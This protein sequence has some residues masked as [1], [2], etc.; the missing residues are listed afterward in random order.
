MLWGDLEMGNLADGTRYVSYTERATK[1][2]KG[3]NT[4]PRM[5]KPKIFEEP[6]IHLFKSKYKIKLSKYALLVVPTKIT[7]NMPSKILFVAMGGNSQMG[8]R[9][10][11]GMAACN[12][13]IKKKNFSTCDPHCPVKMYLK[14]ESRRPL[15]AL[16][17]EARF[18]L[19][20]NHQAKAKDQCWFVNQPMGKIK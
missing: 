7:M 2:R 12:Q 17:P 14:Y 16:H 18:Y 13:N 20:I 15:N 3:I 4:D 6:G 10:E 1:T 11:V 8:Q 9:A 5:F 19:G